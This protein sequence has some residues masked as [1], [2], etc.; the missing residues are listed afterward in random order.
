MPGSDLD[1]IN[2]LGFL[3]GETHLNE[4]INGVAIVEELTHSQACPPSLRMMYC[5]D[6]RGDLDPGGP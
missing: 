3:S 2:S 1:T 5:L 6:N 4:R